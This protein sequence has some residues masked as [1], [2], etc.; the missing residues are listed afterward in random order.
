M[1]SA[2]VREAQ[3][4][5]AYGRDELAVAVQQLAPAF[6]PRLE[7]AGLV[8]LVS[9]LWGSLLFVAVQFALP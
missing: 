2:H 5:I 7:L 8:T 3:L 9:V 1:R 4:A 6:V